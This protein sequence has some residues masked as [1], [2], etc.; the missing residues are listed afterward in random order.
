MLI[1][2]PRIGIMGGEQI[3]GPQ[4]AIFIITDN[5]CRVVWEVYASLAMQIISSE[6]QAFYFC[7][8]LDHSR[9]FRVL[10]T[11]EASCQFKNILS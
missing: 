3:S 7:V 4:N 2:T 10:K 11:H 5:H 9:D 8:K 1:H 6:L